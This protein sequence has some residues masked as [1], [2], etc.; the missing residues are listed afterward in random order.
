MVGE[1]FVFD[2]VRTPRGRG[3][4][5]G[6]LY[7]VK[8][9]RLLATV[10]DALASRNDLDTEAVDDIIMGI[11]DPLG[12][13]GSVVP[14]TAASLCGWHERVAGLQLNRFCASG[15]EAVNIA[16][17][18]VASGQADLIVAGGLESMSRV[19]MGSDGGA[20]FEDPEVSIE[21]AYIPQ[22]ISADLIATIGNFLRED[23]DNYATESHRRAAAAR[24]EGRFSR[25]IVPIADSNGLPILVQDELVRPDTSVA[26]LAALKPSFC[27]VGKAGFEAIAL[28]RYPDVREIAYVHTPGNSSGIADGAAAVL[29]GS[30][31]AGKA[32]GLEPRARIA[33]ALTLST[34]PTIMLTG[35]APTTAR[36]LKRHGL[37]PDDVDL[38]ECNEAF[39]AV[40]LRF[41]SELGIA[42]DRVNVNGGAIALGHPLGATGGMLLGTLVDELER[43]EL[44]RGVVTL[45]AGGGMGI[46]TLVECV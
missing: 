37:K 16:A 5:G 40:V 2:A 1:A 31:A 19:P 32:V 27:R 30:A 4:V 43:R 46:A 15:L 42:H 22:G 10:L 38:F 26:G 6:S 21:T 8:P 18:K 45:C 41:M 25:S 44:K 13:Q 24:S 17:A 39:A 20:W 7:E 36:L 14:K 23:V 34:E 28:R 12:E 3:K 9:V 35:P 33:G 11:V 29:I